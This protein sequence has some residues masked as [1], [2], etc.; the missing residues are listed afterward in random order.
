MRFPASRNQKKLTSNHTL[1]LFLYG[2]MWTWYDQPVLTPDDIYLVWKGR[3]CLPFEANSSKVLILWKGQMYLIWYFKF[4]ESVNIKIK[5]MNRWW[6]ISSLCPY[7]ILWIS[8]NYPIPLKNM[9]YISRWSH[10]KST[11]EL[12]LKERAGE[13]FNVV[14]SVRTINWNSGLEKSVTEENFPTSLISNIL[15]LLPSYT[16][17]AESTNC[18][19]STTLMAHVSK[20]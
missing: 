19:E 20:R 15:C 16:L 18:N 3:G 4:A 7:S 13:S 10:F 5:R 17:Y 11:L 14:A 12:L 2:Q 1:L 8:Y 6:R 9:S